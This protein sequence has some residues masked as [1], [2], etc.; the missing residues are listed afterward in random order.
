MRALLGSLLALTLFASVPRATTLVPATL[1]QV[2][3]DALA[4]VRGRVSAVDARWT[5]D[6][7]TIETIVTLGAESYL[8]GSLG[9]TVQFRVPGGLLG[10]YRDTVVGA[11]QFA[12]GQRV[13]VFL[14]AR[15]PSL[16]Y[17][18]GFSQGVYRIVPAADDSGWL[19]TPPAI[20]GSAG[21]VT[22]IVR[23]DASLRPLPL[24][25]FERSVRATVED[26]R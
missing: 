10:R 24:D 22:P 19:V 3:R 14:G 6:H 1:T 2:S 12:V 11:P 20:P 4:I 8:K 25:A 9:S 16:A 17:L 21:A 7:K 15:G 13:I 5:A 23:G 26:A 18:V